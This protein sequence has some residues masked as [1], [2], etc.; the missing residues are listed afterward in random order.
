MR[1][2]IDGT[3]VRTQADLHRLL[4]GALDFGPYYG[5]NLN[6]LWDRL[7]T[8]VERPVDLVWRHS[9]T[10][11]ALMGKEEF[12]QVQDLLLEVQRQDESFDRSDRFTVLFP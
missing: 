5:A 1:V 10:S 7:T 12:T 9:E 2:E 6:A 3:R 8:D 11:R 4:A